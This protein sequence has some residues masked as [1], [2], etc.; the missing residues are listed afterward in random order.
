MVSLTG[1][2]LC[3]AADIIPSKKNEASLTSRPYTR[4]FTLHKDHLRASF[5]G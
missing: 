1:K 3:V 2:V 4:K 5:I